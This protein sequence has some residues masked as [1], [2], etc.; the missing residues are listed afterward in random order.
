MHDADIVIMDEPTASL[1]QKE[2]DEL[3][4]IIRNLK[5]KQIN[6]FYIAQTR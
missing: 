5:T 3:Y 2:I 4:V 1:S 6:N